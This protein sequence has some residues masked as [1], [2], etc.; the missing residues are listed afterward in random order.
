[1]DPACSWPDQ[2]AVIVLYVLPFC[3][4]ANS[5]FLGSPQREE[6]GSTPQRRNGVHM[7][8][9][10]GSGRAEALCHSSPAPWSPECVW[11]F[12]ESP[13]FRRRSHPLGPG[14]GGL[15]STSTSATPPLGGQVTPLNSSPWTV[16]ASGKQQRGPGTW[17]GSLTYRQ[18]EAG[19]PLS[20]ARVNKCP[21]R[22]AH[23]AK[24]VDPGQGPKQGNKDD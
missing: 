1:M 24:D 22:S 2:S 21:V 14:R 19:L 9:E 15:L 7:G 23:L 11:S 4:T 5:W 20:R 16:Q 13:S 3:C 10:E 17:K 6:V 18:W 8:T 12:R